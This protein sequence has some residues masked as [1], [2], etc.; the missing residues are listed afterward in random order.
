M[1]AKLSRHGSFRKHQ[2]QK[3]FKKI[4]QEIL[5]VLFVL[6]SD[7]LLKSNDYPDFGRFQPNLRFFSK[8]SPPSKDEETQNLVMNV[9]ENIWFLRFIENFNLKK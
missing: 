9:S 8:I 7:H 2:V 6:K 1:E 3:F 5:L 4:L